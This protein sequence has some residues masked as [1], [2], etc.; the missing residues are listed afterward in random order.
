MAPSNHW[1][2]SFDWTKVSVVEEVKIEWHF[3]WGRGWFE[4]EFLLK[5]F[6]V[7]FE[8]VLVELEALLYTF[9][10]GD[11]ER[12]LSS[13]RSYGAT[14]LGLGLRRVPISRAFFWARLQDSKRNAWTIVELSDKAAVRERNVYP[15]AWIH[16]FSRSGD[17][18]Q[19]NDFL[20]HFR[21][22]HVQSVMRIWAVGKETRCDT[23]FCPLYFASS[24]S[25]RR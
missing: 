4:N 23:V 8:M 21:S 15:E 19:S 5:I 1:D 11:G 16:L 13:F 12:K 18:S 14:R 22:V 2:F 10:R 20:S 24:R 9:S 7:A 6:S 3:D 25:W 17:W